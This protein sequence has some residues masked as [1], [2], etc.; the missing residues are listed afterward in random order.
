MRIK[1][2]MTKRHTLG[3]SPES[4]SGKVVA[5]KNKL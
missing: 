3:Y 5:L 1:S 2:S 4:N